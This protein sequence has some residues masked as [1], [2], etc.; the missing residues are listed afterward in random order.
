MP[1]PKVFSPLQGRLSLLA[2]SSGE[3]SG[4][5]LLPSPLTCTSPPLRRSARANLSISVAPGGPDGEQISMLDVP[6][7]SQAPA[8]SRIPRG[9]HPAE[10]LRGPDALSWDCR[11]DSLPAKA[12]AR[13]V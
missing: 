1:S 7:A 3:S 13:P 6:L 2:T 10:R 4:S 9:R 5:T 11:G 8:E 12:S